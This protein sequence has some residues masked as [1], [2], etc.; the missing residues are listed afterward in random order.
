MAQRAHP[1]K[2]TFTVT[3]RNI[4]AATS[5]IDALSTDGGA[6]IHE[7]LISALNLTASVVTGQHKNARTAI[8]LLTAG[9][10]TEG[11]TDVE[12]IRS[13]V[14]A[15]NHVQKVPIFSFGFG[16]DVDFSFLHE[17]SL[18]SGVAAKRVHESDDCAHETA[19]ISFLVLAF[20]YSSDLFNFTELTR[21][22]FNLT[23]A[24]EL[25]TEGV[26]IAGKIQTVAD[27]LTSIPSCI[28]R[29]FTT[30][31]NPMTGLNGTA[32]LNLVRAT[33]TLINMSGDKLGEEEGGDVVSCE[34][35][36]VSA[37]DIYR[38]NGLF[39]EDGHDGLTERIWAL[40]SIKQLIEQA[41]AD[42]HGTTDEDS[43]A[44]RALDLALRVSSVGTLFDLKLL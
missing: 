6:N 40:L 10:A 28:D 23:L 21:T 7:A 30:E 19:C 24:S 14:K 29:N 37:K 9:N 15:E 2:A 41:E 16:N 25:A 44:Q 3:Q 26:T 34:N 18:E 20:S 8:L 12:Q 42:Q 5:F 39:D 4:Q 22:N 11:I 36:T 32:L 33:L 31:T 38:I 17:L 35:S 1:T 13:A 43:P 27:G